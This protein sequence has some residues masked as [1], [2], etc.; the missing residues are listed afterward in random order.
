MSSTRETV[1][2][3]H[4]L[5][6]GPLGATGAIPAPVV[7]APAIP[8]LEVGEPLGRGGMGVVFRAREVATGRAVAVKWLPAR[9][10]EALRRRFEREARALAAVRHP[11]IVPVLSA[12]SVAE[13]S[14]IVMELVD[15]FTLS[16]AL[17]ARALGRNALLDL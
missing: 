14:F 9:A 1:T 5:P 15:G 16:D 3:I 10:D 2:P 4:A 17:V 13:G 6:T 12:G 7:E 8:G 11:H